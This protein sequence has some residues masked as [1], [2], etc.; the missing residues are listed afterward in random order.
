MSKLL[1]MGH[2]TLWVRRVGGEEF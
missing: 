1:R 2:L